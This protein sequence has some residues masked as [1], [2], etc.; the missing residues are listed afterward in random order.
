MES[1]VDQIYAHHIKNLPADLRL[2]LLAL[3]ADGL[4]GEAAASKKERSLLELEGLGAGLWEGLDAQKYVD[5][6][7]REWGH[8]P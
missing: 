8:R 1:T 5:D 4:A 7:R 2:R 3:L 6:L